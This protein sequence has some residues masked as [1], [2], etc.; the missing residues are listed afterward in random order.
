MHALS[1]CLAALAFTSGTLL[2]QSLVVPAGATNA[3]I[4]TTPNIWPA[5][6]VRVQ[7]FYD[8][9]HFTSQLALAVPITIDRLEFRLA[10]AAATNIVVYGSVHAYL[11]YSAVDYTTP[12]TT[13]A[14]NRTVPMPTTPNYNGPVTTLAVSGSSP[15]DY[16]VDLP[17]QVPFTYDPTI[18]QDLLLEL[19]VWSAPTPN[20]GNSTSSA[21]VVATHMCNSIRRFGSTTDS[22][23]TQSAFPPI[24]RLGYTPVAGAAFNATLGQ[25]CYRRYRSFY[26]LFASS[27]NDLTGHTVTMTQNGA[28]GYDVGTAPGASVTAPTTAGLGLGDDEVSVAVPLPFTFHYPGGSTNQIFV[29]AN[30][31]V[32]L[33]ATGPSTNAGNLANLLNSPAPRLAAA[34]TDLLPDG[35][36]N[37]ANV[38]AEVDPGNPGAFLITWNNVPCFGAVTP[39]RFQIALIDNGTDDV[40]Q[41]RYE[42]L[43]NDATTFG[44]QC[45][46]GFSL[47][48]GAFDPGS[49][50][51]TAGMLSTIVD[52]APVAVVALTRPVIDSPWNMRT[53]G[54]PPTGVIGVDIFGLAD[55]GVDDLFFVGLPGCGL[56]STLDIQNPWLVTG[57]THNYGLVLPNE[58]S[59]NGLIFYTTSAVFTVPPANDFGAMTGNGIAG[60]LGTL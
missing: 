27:A 6:T 60:V 11:S 25:G 40:V 4:G 55:P 1:T 54:I 15:N 32:L 31:N 13:F 58:P 9:S 57:A 17:L 23:G 18:G 8:S 50:D 45:L 52:T 38:H 33:G 51:L 28:G 34:L 53:T 42:T 41:Y 56:R 7:C 22:T 5:N 37:V 30:G 20:V 36:T 26:E 43:V 10:N 48:N 44:G 19:V 49:S 16:F 59:W 39:S 21:S 24:V 46:T 12:S 3:Q 35:A 47:G 29:D 14:N 2:A